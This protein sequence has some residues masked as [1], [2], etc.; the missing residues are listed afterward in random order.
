[1]DQELLDQAI[2]LAARGYQV[3]VEREEDENSIHVWVAYLPEMPSC[4]AQG[5]TVESAIEELKTVRED[6]IYFRLKRGVPVPE[7]KPRTR[8]PISNDTRTKRADAEV[9]SST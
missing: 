8:A 7:P 6:Y 5:E 9:I 2:R 4:S 3:A 1:M